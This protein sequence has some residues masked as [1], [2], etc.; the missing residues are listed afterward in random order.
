[1]PQ[2]CSLLSPAF[3]FRWMCSDKRWQMVIYE[4][5]SC[6]WLQS[7]GITTPALKVLVNFCFVYV[8]S[9]P[10]VRVVDLYS[11]PSS[12]SSCSTSEDN[13]EDISDLSNFF[14]FPVICRLCTN[15]WISGRYSTWWALQFS[16]EDCLHFFSSLTK[17]LALVALL[18]INLLTR[19]MNYDHSEKMY[20]LSV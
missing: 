9:L 11:V 14:L 13:S 17:G 10:T 4:M 16:I 19:L 12:I 20:L 6:S 2:C 8:F 3:T 5:D 1:M 7:L 18:Y 15:S